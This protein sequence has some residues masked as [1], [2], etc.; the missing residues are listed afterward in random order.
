MT[1]PAAALGDDHPAVLCAG[2]NLANVYGDRGLYDHAERSERQ[3]VEGLRRRVG[4][5]RP[6]VL[7][8]MV[9][10]A[11]TLRDTGREEAVRLQEKAATRPAQ[12][13]G[14]NHPV[15]ALVRAWQRVGRELEPHQT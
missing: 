13:L 4:A 12:L 9:N 8:G 14:R 15:T 11:I 7:A 10:L 3:A 1:G 2:L 5:E 6:D